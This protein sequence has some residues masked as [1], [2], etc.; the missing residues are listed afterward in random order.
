M[1]YNSGSTELIN[2]LQDDLAISSSEI[3]VALRHRQ[4]LED[5]LPMLLWLYGL[6]SVEQLQR[7]FDWQESHY[8]AN[9]S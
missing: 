3:A 2:F 1:E 4:R 9:L 8:S 6:L 7:V 5:P